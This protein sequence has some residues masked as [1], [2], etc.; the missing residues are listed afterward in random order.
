MLDGTLVDVTALDPS[1]A[2]AAGGMGSYLSDLELWAPAFAAGQLITAETFAKQTSFNGQSDF[3]YG[4]GIMKIWGFLGHDGEIDG[5][6]T[7]MFYLPEKKA[8][9][10]VLMNKSSGNSAALELFQAMAKIVFPEQFP[11]EEAQ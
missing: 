1:G 2:W 3:Q 7:A 11:A 5:Y 6:N 10:V 4:L 8:T 9:I